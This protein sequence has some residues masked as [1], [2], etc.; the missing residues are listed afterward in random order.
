[1]IRRMYLIGVWYSETIVLVEHY[2]LDINIFPTRRSILSRECLGQR[3]GEVIE[4]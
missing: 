3:D 2:C 4:G 1:M